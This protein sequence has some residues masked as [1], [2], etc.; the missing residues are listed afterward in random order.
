M[1]S[2]IPAAHVDDADCADFLIVTDPRSTAQGETLQTFVAATIKTITHD[3]GSRAEVHLHD[4]R[5]LLVALDGSVSEWG[6]DS[7]LHRPDRN[8]A[9]CRGCGLLACDYDCDDSQT[10]SC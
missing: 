4:G 8:V 6:V 10:A 3:A 2:T 1:D 9:Y 5:V 7:D